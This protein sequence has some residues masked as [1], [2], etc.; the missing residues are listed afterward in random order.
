MPSIGNMLSPHLVE[1]YTDIYTNVYGADTS[2]SDII[3]KFDNY[4]KMVINSNALDI[5]FNILLTLGVVLMLLY[6]FMDLSAKAAMQQLTLLQMGKSFCLLIGT[7]FVMF[8]CKQIFIFML[9]IVE[10][11]NTSLQNVNIGYNA[12][13]KF[14]SNDV[15]KILLSRCVGEQFNLGAILGYTLTALLINLISLAAKI[16]I[17]Y[18]AATRAVQLFVYYIFA[19]VGVADIFQNGPGGTINRDSSGFRYLKT[20]LALMMQI[21]VITVVCQTFPIVTYAINAGYYQDE[22]DNINSDDMLMQQYLAVYPILQFEYTDHYAPIQAIASEAKNK[23]RDALQGYQLANGDL[24]AGDTEENAEK[25]SDDE[26]Y[27]I[28][29]VV[30]GNGEITNEAEAEKIVD[31]SHYRMTIQSTEMFFNW[32]TG[33]DGGKMVLF[34]ILLGV[35]IL[36]IY[37]SSKLCN[38]IIGTAI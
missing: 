29:N 19:P 3:L 32:C 2:Y 9:E 6:F 17:I 37:S 33:A 31:N 24:E 28:S 15:V 26:I 16:Y 25:L 34:I 38:Y 8:H 30:G 27:P 22:G 35:K 11:L 21:V 23:V 12:V 7:V 10:S 20:I 36:M 5:F 1:W 14:M 4:L 18:Y 13:S